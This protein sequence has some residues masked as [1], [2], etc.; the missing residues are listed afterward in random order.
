MY[1]VTITFNVNGQIISCSEKDTTLLSD[2]IDLIKARFNF[3]PE[4]QGYIKTAIFKSSTKRPYSK[5]LVDDACMVPSE[6]IKKSNYMSVSV[7][8]VSGTQL[9]TATDQI[10]PLTPSGYTDD[11][12]VSPAPAEN[13]YQQI[14]TIMQKQAFDAV[15][16]ETAQDKAEKASNDTSGAISTHNN[17]VGAHASLFAAVMA[18]NDVT[19]QAI[20]QVL[21]A[22]EGAE[23]EEIALESQGR[24]AIEKDGSIVISQNLSENYRVSNFVEVQPGEIYSITASGYYSKML[25]AFY[26]EN[27][28]LLA[29]QLETTTVA[30]VKIHDKLVVAPAN[31]AKLRIAWINEA[32]FVGKITVVN[33]LIFPTGRLTGELL[34]DYEYLNEKAQEA[35]DHAAEEL[36]S[37]D[38]SYTEENVEFEIIS[39]K[40][41]PASTGVPI[42]LVHPSDNYKVS[43][44]I[45]VTPME[46]LHIYACNNYKNCVYV[47]YDANEK[48]IDKLVA[49]EGGPVTKFDGKIVAPLRA[50][51]L[52]ISYMTTTLTGFVKRMTRSGFVGN[53]SGTFKGSIDGIFKWAGKKWAT[54]GDS[55]TEHNIRATKNYHD[56]VAEKTGITVV[57]LGSSGSGYK[58]RWEDNKAFYQLLDGI[59]IDTDMV[60]FYG[61]G[62]DLAT[63][64][65]AV[66]DTGTDTLCGCINTTIDRYNELFPGKPLGIVTPCPWEG[67]NPS[68]PNNKM[69]LYSDAI[70]EICRRRSIPCLDLYHC[71]NLRP[72]EAA[73]RGLFYTRDNGGGCHP[74]E[75]GHAILAPKFAAFLEQ[76]IL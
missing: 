65:G 29:G 4:W 31:A 28:H 62:N 14:V 6:A 49:G 23:I 1:N 47:F 52:R 48:M 7:F 30:P 21:D 3:S 45:S 20:Q 41:L 74:D 22:A 59:P 57:N 70:V 71:S 8:G 17:D 12:I 72:W 42:D 61:S 69:A 66:T 39:S 58:R 46:S 35:L 75:N 25:Y 37:D 13:I 51:Y 76:L 36:I 38:Y 19:E 33:K 24:A 11:S 67:N 16:A 56:Y 10:V 34:E 73:F 55:H 43:G 26:D 44:M 15:R 64:L 5:I 9:I 54:I 2:S 32:T 50:A 63:D 68:N 18:D 60:T 27:D 53:F 40:V